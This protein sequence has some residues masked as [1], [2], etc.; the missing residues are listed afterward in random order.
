[1]KIINTFTKEEGSVFIC[2]VIAHLLSDFFLQRNKMVEEKRWFSLSMLAHICIVFIT[3]LIF[4][5]NI[6]IALAVSVLHYLIDG[7]KKV[8]EKREIG[9]E[10]SRFLCD[11]SAHLIT[12]FVI[13]LIYFSLWEELISLFEIPEVT[14]QYGLITVGYLFVIGPIGY[15]IKFATKATAKNWSKTAEDLNP[16]GG[17]LIGIFERIIILTFVLLGKYEAIGFLITGKSI[18][19]FADKNSDLRSEYVLLGTMMSY[20]LSILVGVLMNYLLG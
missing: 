6:W 15:I 19:R 3:T 7:L 11:Q 17:M 13:W 12:L 9:T 16:N 2:L 20:A 4:V 18:I 8:A 1:M 5:Q 10:L 14:Y